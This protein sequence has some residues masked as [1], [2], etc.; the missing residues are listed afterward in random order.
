[1]ARTRP[2]STDIIWLALLGTLGALLVVPAPACAREPLRDE[3]VVWYANDREPIPTPEFEEPGLVP[4]AVDSFVGRPFSRFWHP[5]RFSRWV[6]TG[7]RAQEAADINS[8][9]EEA[10]LSE[11]DIA[12]RMAK[13]SVLRAYDGGLAA[14]LDYE[15]RAFQVTFAT[16]DKTEGTTAFIEKRKPDFKGR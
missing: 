5:G 15:R 8:L 13:A 16:D 14:G 3:P 6:G 10:T 2:R 4:Y 1:M 9:D 11:A 12:V 7:D